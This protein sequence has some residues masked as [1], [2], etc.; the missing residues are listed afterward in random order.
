MSTMLYKLSASRKIGDGVIKDCEKF[1]D[2]IIVK[3]DETK[4]NIS[5][6]W[7]KTTTAAAKTKPELRKKV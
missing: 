1:F 2:Y 5:N 6:G 3:D 7:H 4:T